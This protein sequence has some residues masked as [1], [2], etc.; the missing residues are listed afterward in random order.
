MIFEIRENDVEGCR[1]NGERV[2]E[3]SLTKGDQIKLGKTV[4]LFLDKSDR[5][6]ISKPRK[7]GAGEKQSGGILKTWQKRYFVLQGHM[8]YYWK[9]K[10]EV[11][12]RVWMIFFR[13]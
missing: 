4:L 13:E 12:V 7:E 8:L 2:S 6:F 5:S 11:V 9:S 1:I 3:R 10:K